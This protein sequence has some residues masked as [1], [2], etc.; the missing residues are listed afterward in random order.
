MVLE[1]LILPSSAATLQIEQ[2]ISLGHDLKTS[3]QNILSGVPQGS[4]LRPLLFLLYVN[5]LPNSSVLEPVM[6]ADDTDLFFEH[7]DLRILFSLV[8]DERKKI[9]EWFNANTLSLNAEKT[10]YSLFHR[11]TKTDDLRLLLPKVLINE[12]EVERV[13]STKFL[14]V[15]L[16]EHIS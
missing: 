1:A 10:K 14:G 3:T 2:Y 11:P 15:L 12:K 7:T 6:F 5:D 4:I 13:G 9:Y 8:N 16:D